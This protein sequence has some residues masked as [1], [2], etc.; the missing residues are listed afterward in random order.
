MLKI[1]KATIVIK[2]KEYAFLK[3]TA[4]ELI[5]IEDDCFKEDG[6]MDVNKYNQKMLGLVSKSLKVEDLV[7][8]RKQDIEMSDGTTLTI[9]E[10]GYYNWTNEI[11]K[12]EKFS[13]VKLAKCALRA[14]GVSG[15]IDLSTFKYEDIDKLSMAFFNLYNNE[16][17]KRVVDEVATF[18]FS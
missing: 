13:R 16:E 4:V 8:Y 2:E 12:I 14:T 5:E 15:E 1:E 10:I 18:C 3:P 17:L 11:S 7:E 6:T 9:P